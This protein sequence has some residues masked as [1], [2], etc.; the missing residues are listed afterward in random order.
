[1]PRYHPT[2]LPDGWQVVK[3]SDGWWLQK[4]HPSRL[5]EDVAGP[6]V[7]RWNAVRRY[8]DTESKRE[9]QS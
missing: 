4:R 3:R 9:R 2:I 5:W 6:F 7:E 8:Q 1:M